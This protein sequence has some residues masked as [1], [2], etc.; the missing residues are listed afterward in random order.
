M[1][2]SPLH[3]KSLCAQCN[4]LKY[5]FATISG[6]SSF[7]PA[8]RLTASR[9]NWAI[10]QARGLAEP[11]PSPNLGSAQTFDC[12]VFEVP[13]PGLPALAHLASLPGAPGAD[14]LW[15]GPEHLRRRRATKPASPDCAI[16]TASS[17]CCRLLRN[18]F[19]V[20]VKVASSPPSELV[21][22]KTWKSP[23]STTRWFSRL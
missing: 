7:F 18:Y 2:R 5:R 23:G 21:P 1:F 13:T 14:F 17:L 10:D 9:M 12:R 19:S 15:T 8:L 11:V 20:T 4:Y 3:Q 16:E 6:V 22:T